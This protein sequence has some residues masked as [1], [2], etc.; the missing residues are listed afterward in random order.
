MKIG[1]LTVY[2]FNYGSYFQ[3]TALYKKLES[4]GYECEFINERFKQYRWGNLFLLY[5]FDGILPAF[6][7][8]YIAKYLPQYETY[9]RLKKDVSKYRES[10]KCLHDMRKITSRYDG[11][12][13]GADEMW[14]ANKKSIRYMPEH[15]GERISCPHISYATCGSLFDVHN[16]KL[17]R[18]AAKGMK[19]FTAIGVRD[20]YTKKVADKLTK[21]NHP[22]VIDPTL[23]Y[24]YFISDSSKEKKGAYLLL[25]GQHYSQSQQKYIKNMA[26]EMGL[27]IKALGWP[28][29]FADEFLDPETAEEFQNCFAE[30]SFC[31]PSTFHGTI[32]S[33]LH[34]KP[35]LSMTN[36]LRG[37]KVRM[38]LEQLQLKD[39][40]FDEAKDSYPVID[41]D[42]VEKCLAKQRTFSEAYLRDALLK[43]G[44]TG[45]CAC[46][47]VCPA[48][49]ISMKED[50]QGFLRPQIDADV[51]INCNRCRNV[52]PQNCG[53]QNCGAKSDIPP[54]RKE[55]NLCKPMELYG[56]FSKNVKHVKNSS[57]GG[58][59]GEL[60]AYVLEHGGVVYGAAFTKDKEGALHQRI[61][62]GNQLQELA[63]SKYV[64]SNMDSVYPLLT[65]DLKEGKIVLFSGTPC[66]IAGVQSYVKQTCPKWW[67]HLYTVDILCHGV[68]SPLVF[69]DYIRS[70]KGKEKDSIASLT[71]RDKTF[72][73]RKQAISIHFAGGNQYLKRTDQDVYYRLYF[74]NIMLR[75]SCYN[76]SYIHRN[77]IGDITLGDYWGAEDTGRFSHNQVNNGISYVSIQTEKGRRLFDNISGKIVRIK[78]DEKS[79]YQP[80]FDKAAKRPNNYMEF[81]K[82]YI[83]FGYDYAAKKYS[84]YGALELVVKK[85][86]G[87]VAQKI[88]IY[89]IAQKVY[90][91]FFK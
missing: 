22:V 52:C 57:S 35:F 38:L 17:V 78:A 41:Y 12:I 79:S 71:F 84:R 50:S 64:Q 3:A 34:H 48:N 10:P 20:I 65:K 49:A 63:G 72:G 87:P 77:R 26:R 9:L 29:E 62:S 59:F 37:K 68:P 5:T 69:R 18:K 21:G 4:M 90:F 61:S 75:P 1:I 13:L 7:K 70:Q 46:H 39:F 88:G 2:S 42:K 33:I 31:F 43:I 45:C 6:V 58:I 60:A 24:P 16:K 23:L 66:Q 44:C 15:F 27:P 40:I 83:A 53:L 30:A 82:D 80:L 89:K 76:C 36:H 51:C 28:Q 32:F 11:V 14:S 55:Q 47:F 8:P 56:A 74:K 85:V 86:L 81:W 54:K 91:V 73:W 19:T 25:Y 67:D